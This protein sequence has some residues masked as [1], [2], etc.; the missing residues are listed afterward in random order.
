MIIVVLKPRIL[1][2]IKMVQLQTG[3]SVDKEK[4]PRQSDCERGYAMIKNKKFQL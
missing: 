2:L 3:A 4:D 1:R